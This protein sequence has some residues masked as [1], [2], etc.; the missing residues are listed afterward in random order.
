MKLIYSSPIFRAGDFESM[1][2]IES[3]REMET[4]KVLPIPKGFTVNPLNHF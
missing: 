1:T 4:I 3:L 2:Q